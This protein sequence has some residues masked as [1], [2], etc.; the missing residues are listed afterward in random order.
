MD[1]KDIELEVK[2]KGQDN[3]AK[4]RAPVNPTIDP[5]DF[6]SEPPRHEIKEQP[7]G[8][9]LGDNIPKILS[10]SKQLKFGAAY[11]GEYSQSK[12][13]MM[14][15]NKPQSNEGR[16]SDLHS[17]PIEPQHTEANKKLI[18]NKENQGKP[19]GDSDKYAGKEKE[20]GLGDQPYHKM[21]QEE[22]VNYFGTDY[23]NGLDPGKVESLRKHHGWNEITG[24]PPTPWILKLL[25]NM[26]GGFQIFLWIGGLLCLIVYFITNF[27]DYQ[28]LALGIVCFI[29]VFGTSLFQTFQEGKSDDVMAQLK[30]LTPAKV[31]IR[32]GGKKFDCESRELV[33]GDIIEVSAGQGVPA[34]V[35]VLQSINLKVNNASL[36]GENVDI[37]LNPTTEAKTLYEAKNLARMGCNFTSGS[38]TCI[39]F[40]TGD[41]TFFGHIARSA[42]DIKRPDSCLTREIK[43]LVL[44][45]GVIAV[46]IGVVFLIL[47]FVRGYKAVEAIIFAI[48]I[49]VANVP[50]GLLPQMT[51]ALTLTANKMYE[52]DVIVNNLEIIE[53]LGAVDVIC[54]DKTGTLTCN[55]MTV[56]HMCYD[57][58]LHGIHDN[59]AMK[60]GQNP[61]DFI[62]KKY[63]V[64]NPSFRKLMEI[65]V[66]CSTAKFKD[67]VTN[68]KD[69]DLLDCKIDGD[70]SE[71][72]LIKFLQPLLKNDQFKSNIYRE[73]EKSELIGG[74]PF[75]SDNKWMLHV[76]LPSKN[77]EDTDGKFIYYIKGAPE[78]VLA[79]CSRHLYKGKVV[80]YSKESEIMMVKNEKLAMQGERVLGFAYKVAE[81]IRN[82]ESM[83]ND[84]IDTTKFDFRDFIFVGF[85]SLQ[86]P[87]RPKVK[88]SIGSCYQAGIQ[89]FMV[90]GDQP[91]TAESIAKQLG[92]ISNELVTHKKNN[93]FKKFKEGY[94]VVNGSSLMR[95]T[96]EDWDKTFEYGEV[97]FARTMPQQKQDIVEQLKKKGKI[98]AMTGDGVND[99]P[100]LKAAHVGIAM[101]SG[102]SVAKEAGQLILRHD[103]FNS[104]VAGIQEGRLIFENLKK[105]ICYVLASNIPELIPFLLFIIIKI[106]LAIET[107]MILLVDVGTDLAPA[108]SLAW[109]M[110][111]NETMKLP[112][113]SEHDHLVG[114]R[115]MLVAY[116][117]IGIIQTFCSYWA[118]YW[119]FYDHGFTVSDTVGAGVQYR[120][121][122]DD[123]SI[124]QQ[125]F[126]KNMCLNNVIYQTDHVAAL[127]KNC[128]QDFKDYMVDLLAVAQS[129][130]LMT[131]VWAQ[132][133][134]IFV[135]KTA[136]ET[137]FS[138]KRFTN[139]IP[140]FWSLLIEIAVIIIVVYVPGLNNA[141]LL[142]HVPPV[143]ASTALWVIPLIFILEEIRKYFIRIYPGGCIDNISK[144]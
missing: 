97:V 108:I 87:P 57:L 106:P 59:M 21:S 3:M 67:D 52:K 133:A 76:K 56:A 129:A 47:A 26:F 63:D 46:T 92:L 83:N 100:A 80:P 1:L 134:C 103:D 44:I 118:F 58:E 70:A 143:Y 107:I 65:M 40:S 68:V 48:G 73:R 120:D 78:R 86:D 41:H 72:A 24:K 5:E 12:M 45:M 117:Y 77:I 126:F 2:Q 122:W 138:W 19:A 102:T 140:L 37:N 131:V 60:E 36:T 4:M 121:K 111:E 54:S 95:Y 141:L 17:I 55:R 79:L 135:R 33:P 74:I 11:A 30:K 124:D 69:E 39:V 75:N 96:Q 85:V 64:N 136:S 15:V 38:G 34:D 66:H 93:N 104:I 99:A 7:L 23:E 89:V 25:K 113:R 61:E 119:V 90:T 110:E 130:F 84:N 81:E 29:I 116:L 105:C 128:K 28:T 32:R 137:V 49:I 22:I 88:D 127:G 14:Q 109:E 16:P 82:K 18:D 101:G 43:R 139:N 51:V 31:T 98:I 91:A 132:I 62:E 27:T 142:T 53:T 94:K 71:G 114:L 8:P 20:Y 123:M 6:N 10:Q 13:Q 144:F 35:R 50:E 125:I 112:P 9:E 115:L 42:L